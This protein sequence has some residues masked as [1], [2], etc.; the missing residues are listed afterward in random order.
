ML[1]TMRG[2]SE[3]GEDAEDAEDLAVTMPQIAPA[4]FSK[5][6]RETRLM[7][8]TSTIAGI[9]VMSVVPT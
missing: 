5:M 8:E 1:A 9:M 7:P 4:A 6:A 3:D 2:F